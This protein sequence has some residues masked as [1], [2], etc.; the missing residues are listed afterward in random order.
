LP[1]NS[2]TVAS[3]LRFARLASRLFS[4]EDSLFTRARYFSA[5]GLVREV[6]VPGRGP[7]TWSVYD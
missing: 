3:A 4:C 6:S 7:R 2:S 5:T 1:V